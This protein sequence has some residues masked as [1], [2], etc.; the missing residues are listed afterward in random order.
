MK[1]KTPKFRLEIKE[2][3]SFSLAS[4]EKKET[5]KKRKISNDLSKSKTT[6]YKSN[7]TQE[8][9]ERCWNNY[10]NIKLQNKEFN[11]ASLLKISKPKKLIMNIGYTVS[12]DINKKELEV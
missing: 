12:S 2:V 9:L 11:I 1:K 7:F 4:V 3:S 8:D 10:H 5:F 6:S